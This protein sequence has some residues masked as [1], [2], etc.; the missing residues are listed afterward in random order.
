VLSAGYL[1]GE[2]PPGKLLDLEGAQQAAVRLIFA[3]ARAAAAIRELDLADADGDGEPA[4]IGHAAVANPFYP[5]DPS[6]PADVFGA[7]RISYI[8]N[9]AFIEAWTSGRLDVN[10]DGDFDD[11]DTTPP[12]GRFDELAGTLDWIGVNYYGPGRVEA[13]VFAG[14]EPLHGMPLL[15]VA[16]YD[17]SLPHNEMGREISAAAFL[18]TL[19]MY[20]R[21]GLP[22]YVT[23]NGIGDSTDAQRPFYLLEHVRAMGLAV[24]EGIDIR[25]YLHWSLTDNFEWSYGYGQRFGLYAVDFGDA[26]LPRTERPS[27]GVYRSICAANGIDQAL[28]NAWALERYPS[29]TRP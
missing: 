9:D 10:L 1:A 2:H 13:G 29:D 7:E 24:A 23:E 4:R 6:N 21:W 5:K 22:L 8:V 11:A 14:S 27:A 12:E 17:P 28:W 15:D 26:A 3:H 18:E 19:R 25:G 16:R 20:A